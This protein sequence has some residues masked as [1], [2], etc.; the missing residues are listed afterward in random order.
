[1]STVLQINVSVNYGA[2]GKIAEDIGRLAMAK[3]WRSVIAYGH[4]HNP[5]ENEII[6]IGSSFSVKEHALE[7]RLF[8][9]QGLASR[10]ST[11]RFIE[12][13]KSLKP[14]IIH[15]HNIHGYYLNYKYLFDYLS[16]QRVPVI[17]TLHDCWPFTG[18]CA[19]FDYA[20]CDL[21]KTECH[22]PCIC[23]GNY[24][25]SV[26]F[27][28]SKSNYNTKRHLFSSIDSL[29][30]VPVS[31]WLGD[32]VEQSFMKKYPIQVIHNGID[33]NVF[34]LYEDLDELREKYQLSG[35]HVILGV[36]NEWV[37]RKGLK[38][39]LKLRALLSDDYIIILVGVNAQQLKSLPY[40]IMGIT[41]T[42]N[43][44]EL[45]KLY[46]LA[47]VFMNLTYEDNYPTTNLEAIACGTPVITYNTGG[48]PESVSDGVGWV[49]EKGD[50]NGIVKVLDT[51]SIDEYDRNN[52]RRVCRDYAKKYFD[53]NTCFKSY[54]SLYDSL[55]K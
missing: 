24:P 11:R 18:H 28:R 25:T 8:D 48:S 43:Q 52:T 4:Q 35:K 19:Y 13:V 21:W 23:K 45:A 39:F 54:L 33:L 41:R 51:I 5:S 14:D 6:R 55:L 44:Q 47:D 42:Q 16:S 12:T 37:E 49:V 32:I 15:L 3:G 31:N 22:A 17:W 1:M 27:D 29:T 30:L 26:I 46:S 36:A 40:G 7:S 2:H 50:L 10:W 9:N 53:K 38:D 34:R 20:Q